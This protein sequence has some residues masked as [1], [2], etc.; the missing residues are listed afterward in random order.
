MYYGNVKEKFLKIKIKISL[1][2]KKGQKR[3]RC[4]L[5]QPHVSSEI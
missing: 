2:E 3:A 4:L 5:K 1:K